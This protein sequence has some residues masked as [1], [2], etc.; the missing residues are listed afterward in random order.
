MPNANFHRTAGLIAG[1]TYAYLRSTEQ[2][3]GS[4]VL[5]TA[6]G[7]LGGTLAASLPDVFD[8]PLHPRHR[9]LAHGAVPVGALTSAAV[10]T[11]DGAQVWLRR[12]AAR[13]AS[14]RTAATGTLEQLWH[15]LVELLCRLGAGFSAGLV[16]GYT[17]HVVLDA[18]T[19]AGLP[20][21]A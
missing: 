9:G 14:L 8:P 12:E 5:E 21:L 10:A 3:Y 6:G 4:R 18:L 16:A 11:L 17:S 20:L 7:V 13:R 1:G 19:P 2:S 15:G